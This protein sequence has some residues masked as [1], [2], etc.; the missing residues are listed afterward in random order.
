MKEIS[1]YIKTGNI[2]EDARQIIERARSN[3][4]RSVDFCR[5]QMYWNLGRRILEEEQE[6]KERADYGAYIVKKIGKKPRS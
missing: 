4:V 3:A 6:G 1:I 5:V 2:I